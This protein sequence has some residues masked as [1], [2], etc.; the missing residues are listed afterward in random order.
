MKK[1][2]VIRAFWQKGIFR[3]RLKNFRLGAG[4]S[5]RRFSVAEAALLLMLALLASRGFGVVRQSLF[6]MLFG[7]GPEANAYYAASR[8]PDTIFNLIAGG[9]LTH[10]F[11]PVFFSY[12]KEHG[13]REAWHLTSLVFHVLLVG[14][15][16][17][18]LIGELFAP[19]MV[20]HFVVPGYSPSEQTLTTTLTRIM[21]L[22]PLILGLGTIATA[23][24]NSRSQFLLPALSIAIY[25]FGLIGGLLVTLAFPTVGIYGPTYGI[26]AAA[27]LQVL[28]QVPG[29][30]KQG[31]HYSFVWDLKH[32]GL[33]EV[34]RLLI[35]NAL[36]VA[37]GSISVFVDTAFASYLPDPA[38]LAA[39]HNAQMLYAVPVALVGQAIGPAV[40][41]HLTAQATEGRYI[42][43]RQTVLHMMGL[44]LLFTVPASL[45][46]WLFGGP[47]IH[48]LFQHGAFDLHSSDLTNWALLGYVIGLP[49]IAAGELL[50]NGFFGVKDTRTPLVTNT[51]A[52]VAR[53]GLILFFLHMLSGIWV[54]LA[55]PLATSGSATA[56]ALLM[57]AILLWRLRGKVKIDKGMLRLQRRR[58]YVL[59]REKAPSAVCSNEQKQL[60]AV[61]KTNKETARDTEGGINP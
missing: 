46:F 17:L 14:L 4:F 32:P 33:H 26:L 47:V 54:I 36:A 50:A 53:Y 7:T 11:I 37:V 38:S 59:E 44:S 28:I 25:N 20:T 1:R 21:L 42:R 15:T 22:Q 3:F 40:L 8:L 39:L 48:L 43:L 61:A 29:L 30:L 27:V 31:V 35:P 51:F 56:D 23:I 49:G 6:N 45:L 10:A 34:L 5:L 57:A 60:L 18:V 58:L 41:P 12:E 16:L 2:Q 52:L 19:A 9:A 24:L 55:I 13:Q